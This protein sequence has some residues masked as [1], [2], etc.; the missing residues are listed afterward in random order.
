MSNWQ[1]LFVESFAKG[2][3]KTSATML[4][5]GFV[6]GLYYALTSPKKSLDRFDIQLEPSEPYI[7]DDVTENEEEKEGYGSAIFKKLIELHLV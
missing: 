2:L 6:G 5:F 4:V 3:G 7:R 1:T